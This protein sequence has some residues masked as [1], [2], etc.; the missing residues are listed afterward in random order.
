MT[1]I[2]KLTPAQEAL[3]PVVRDEWLALGLSTAPADRPMAERGIRM[4]YEIAGLAA[5]R[6][7]WCGSPLGNALTRYVVLGF[8]EKLA[9]SGD[10]V[11]ASVW[12]SI[13]AS[14]GASVRA[15]VGA[16]VGASV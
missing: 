13:R 11:G 1:R 4:A 14:V 16:S 10:S 6:V 15:S 2:E 5:P 8:G 3:I 9:M 7:T 12:D